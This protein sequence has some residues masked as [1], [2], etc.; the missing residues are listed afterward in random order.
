VLSESQ[1][2]GGVGAEGNSI[3]PTQ[4]TQLAL[5]TGNSM[6]T[7]QQCVSMDKTQSSGGQVQVSVGS[8][9]CALTS[10]GPLAIIRVTGIDQNSA[11]AT[12]ETQTTQ[13]AVPSL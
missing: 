5:W 9:V 4:G 3:A 11:P 2:G 6:P 10:N 12:I 7:P 13:W 8:V 1:I